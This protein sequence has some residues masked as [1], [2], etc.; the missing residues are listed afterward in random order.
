MDNDVRVVNF[1]GERFGLEDTSPQPLNRFLL[2]VF[3][4][5]RSPG[6]GRATC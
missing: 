2:S 5:A 6:L 1:F 3:V 4:L